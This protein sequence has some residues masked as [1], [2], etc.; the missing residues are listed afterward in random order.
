MRVGASGEERTPPNPG[1][2]LRCAAGLSLPGRLR[3]PAGE[4]EKGL[5]SRGGGG[6]FRDQ[7]GK[8]SFFPSEAESVFTRKWLCG[9]DRTWKAGH[10]VQKAPRLLAGRSGGL[11]AGNDMCVMKTLLDGG[12]GSESHG[13]NER[14]SRYL[15]QREGREVR[16]GG[17]REHWT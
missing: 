17:P 7:K 8:S 2:G 10:W 6:A 4:L 13:N 16:G 9:G 15:V 1:T 14:W 5:A 11:N 12:R 3:A